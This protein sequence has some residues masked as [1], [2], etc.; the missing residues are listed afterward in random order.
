MAEAIT[1][2]Q[3]VT[4][5]RPFVRATTP[6]L[7][8]LRE[9][10]PLGLVRRVLP[11]AT[12]PETKALPASTGDAE[13]AKAL[14]TVD[15]S[16]R[17][18]LLDGLESLKV[19]GTQAWSEMTVTERDNWW[20]N[21]VGRFTVLL[22]SIPGLGGAL[23]DRLPIQDALATAGQGLLLSAMAA[24][25]G[26]TDQ[27]DRV[28]LIAAVLFDRHIDPDLA[29]GKDDHLTREQED[30]TTAELTG[31]LD[32]SARKHGKITVKAATNTL[33]RFGRTLY[34]L[35]DELD[36]RP[37]GRFYHKAVGLLPVVGMAADYLGERSALKRAAKKARRWLDAHPAPTSA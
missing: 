20:V 30:A 19:P 10:D 25:H 14:A 37:Q 6:L 8:A 27:A 13:D 35:G 3:V 34:A 33:W 9:S 22:A 11:S 1:D 12:R 4:V 15:R 31:D 7:S 32:E 21:R 5:L 16:R 24:E 26:I 23:A 17:E 29:A 36:K 28:R 18:K 2:R